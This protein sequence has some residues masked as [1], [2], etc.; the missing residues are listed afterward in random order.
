M[1]RRTAVAVLTGT[2]LLGALGAPAVADPVLPEGQDTTT[3]CVR[4][5]SSSGKRDGVCVWLPLDR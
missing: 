2:V 5:D 1:S 4:T 3:V